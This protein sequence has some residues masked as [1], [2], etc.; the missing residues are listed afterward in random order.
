[1]DGVFGTDRYGFDSKLVQKSLAP[2][3]GRSHYHHGSFRLDVRHL[4]D[5]PRPSRRSDYLRRKS[6]MSDRH[7]GSLGA[8]QSY[9]LGIE[10]LRKRVDD[11]GAKPGFNRSFTRHLRDALCLDGLERHSV[12][13]IL[14][15]GSGQLEAVPQGR[16]TT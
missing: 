3:H 16:E 13:S 11:A 10:L 1:M 9:N 15:I 5:R 6:G 4:D 2:A 14:L 12:P 8:A 7:G